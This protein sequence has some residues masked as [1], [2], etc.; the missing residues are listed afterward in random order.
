MCSIVYV[1]DTKT[2][3]QIDSV[4]F[5]TSLNISD[6]RMSEM[7]MNVLRAINEYKPLFLCGF[8]KNPVSLSEDMYTRKKGQSSK[9]IY[10][11]HHS[12]SS[13]CKFFLDT[14]YSKPEIDRMKFYG[15]KE[16]YPHQIMKHEIAKA[17]REGGYDAE[18]ENVVP[19]STLYKYDT[20]NEL[21]KCL[22][23][24]PDITVKNDKMKFAVEIL[25]D[26]TFYPV[27]KDRLNF[28]KESKQHVLLVLNRFNPRDVKSSIPNDILSLTNGNIFEFDDE[29]MWE[30]KQY[31]K[32]VLRCHIARPVLKDDKTL[33]CVW[34]DRKVCIDDLKF[35]DK[36]VSGYWFDC[37][38]CKKNLLD[39]HNKETGTVSTDEETFYI[40]EED[41][42]VPENS[43]ESFRLLLKGE[44][45]FLDSR[46]YGDTIQFFYNLY[47]KEFYTADCHVDELKTI[48]NKFPQHICDFLKQLIRVAN[49]FPEY[50]EAACR[51]LCNIDLDYDI[52]EVF[53]ADNSIFQT[54]WN[55]SD[56]PFHLR[57]YLILL[58]RKDYFI[59]ESFNKRC[60]K[61][62]IELKKSK[63]SKALPQD[64]RIQIE[65]SVVTLML[66]KL[67]DLNLPEYFELLEV[68]HSFRF[69]IRL[70][71]YTLGI[72]LGCAHPNLAALTST[73]NDSHGKFAHLTVEMIEAC[74][75]DKDA[76]INHNFMRLKKTSQTDQDYS[77]DDLV[78]TL[79]KVFNKKAGTINAIRA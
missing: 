74:N 27:M 40:P 20:Q 13:E 6:E 67:D 23:R 43:E 45:D 2:Q 19:V 30:S 26:T 77:Y 73:M 71:S 58:N 28:Y 33:S 62:L 57:S 66:N 49:D 47:N 17:L 9:E 65:K 52:S 1:I 46:G 72:P 60:Q 76:I 16:G 42:H 75:L 35:N 22:W 37:R 69:L 34:I 70:A 53:G 14:E 8:C 78:Y 21:Y 61:N 44:I 79:F 59:P 15:L 55:I 31:G 36:F 64:E 41:H 54:A 11:K 7:R 18:I 48:N 32:L 50:R 51:I 68:E 12:P 24:R 10:F 25:V 39:T 63:R 5:L 4:K 38:A 56:T 3:E 29:M